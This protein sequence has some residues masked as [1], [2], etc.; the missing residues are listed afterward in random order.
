MAFEGNRKAFLERANAV[1]NVI[2]D[3]I[4]K[5]S[6]FV[7]VSHHDADGLSSAGIMGSALTRTNARFTLRIV[8]EL[9]EDIVNEI[10][11]T[12][13]DIAIFTDIGSGYLDLLN[14]HL[15]AKTAII[16]DHHPPNAEAPGQIM[17]LNPHE[18]GIDGATKV[19]AAG[20]TYLVAR[21]MS[22]NNKDLS[23]LGIVGALGDM[24]DKN[25]KRALMGLN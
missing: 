24:Q 11:K 9:R 1:A 15:E 23:A 2:K 25:E 7:A 21:A 3:N 6:F 16:L 14:S 4:Q 13:P 19:S 20:V 8:E 18:F 12:K 10:S 5:D 17:Q 22:Q